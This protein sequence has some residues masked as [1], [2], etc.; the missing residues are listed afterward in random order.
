MKKEKVDVLLKYYLSISGTKHLHYGYWKE[1]EELTMKNMRFAQ[2]R[3]ADHLIS[4]I[5]HEVRTVLDVGCGVGG[6]SLKLLEK[7]Y[8]VAALSPDFYQCKVFKEN[9][10][11]EVPFH[12]TT[13]EEFESQEKFDLILMAESCQY[14]DIEKGLKK[15]RDIVTPEGYLLVA[16]YF[17]VDEQYLDLPLS[18]HPLIKYLKKAEDAGFKTLK[19]E[20][21]TSRVSR[22]LDF[23]KEFY[24]DYLMPTLKII[25]FSIKVHA[26]FFYTLGNF[27]LGRIAR[28][29]INRGFEEPGVVDSK[30]FAE[31]RKYMI[32]LFQ[33]S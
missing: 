13:F 11:V 20:D 24:R 8:R 10:Q 32:Y 21:I 17:E 15:C 1:G 28:K 7:G 12:L 3:Y 4:F 14:I 16:D 2:E 25:A 18:G 27:F 23:R 6:T 29:M 30:I 5:P 9:V 22:T 31:H 33:L 26:P 19:S